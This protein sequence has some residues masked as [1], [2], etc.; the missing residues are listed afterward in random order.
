MRMFDQIGNTLKS[1]RMHLFGKGA[2]TLAVMAASAFTGS[3]L[4]LGIV[5]AGGVVLTAVNRFYREGL[6]QDDM[7]NLYRNDIAAQFGIAPGEVTRGHLKE[8][9]KSND[10]IDQA[11]TRM[12]MKT[13]VNIATASAASLVTVGLVGAFGADNLLKRGVSDM[14]GSSTL[15]GVANFIGIGTVAGMSSLVFN[16]GL[17]TVLGASTPLGKAAAHDRIL[18]MELDISHGRSVS[19]EQ[20][21]GVLVAADPQL[22]EAI[23]H[24]FGKRWR[25][26]HGHQRG[27][28]LADVGIGAEMQQLAD[29]INARELRPGSLAYMLQDVNEM[30]RAPER[31]S[32]AVGQLQERERGN[33]VERLGLAPREQASFAERL[34][35]QSRE[36]QLSGGRA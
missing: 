17:R 11:L 34:D 29:R 33:F 8:A 1:L 13:W 5:A 18:Q 23:A 6:Y 14:L 3:T 10:V 26:M 22:Q 4:V 30:M 2:M 32:E 28:V 24:R 31:A 21:Y 19:K 7:V 12:R 36:A 35:T 16:N 15:A 27:V 20:V 25:H 9:A